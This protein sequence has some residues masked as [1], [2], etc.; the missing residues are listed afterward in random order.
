MRTTINVMPQFLCGSIPGQFD[1]ILGKTDGC[2]EICQ[3]IIEIY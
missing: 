3:D 2:T 1:E